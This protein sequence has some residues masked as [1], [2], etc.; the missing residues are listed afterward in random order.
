MKPTRLLIPAFAVAMLASA[1]N[2]SA[3]QYDDPPPFQY[4]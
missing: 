1:G 4:G 2:A 3:Q